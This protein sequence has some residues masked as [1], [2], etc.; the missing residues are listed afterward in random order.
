MALNALGDTLGAIE[1]FRAVIEVE[2][3]YATAHFNLGN[4][5]DAHGYAKDALKSLETAIAL[6]PRFAPAHFGLGHAQAKLGLHED[7]VRHFERAAVGLDPKYGVAWLCR[8]NSHLATGNHRAAIRAFEQALR[9]DLDMPA[10]HLNR[11]LALLAGD[12][13]RGLPAYEWRLQTAG[14]EFAPPLPRWN[15]EPIPGAT[16]VVRAEQGFGDTPQQRC[17]RCASK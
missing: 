13:A 1:H 11:A 8:G 10:A 3:K 5:L 6:Q 16:L 17:M 4:L 15:G 12:Y 9:L 14:S 2:P 7:A